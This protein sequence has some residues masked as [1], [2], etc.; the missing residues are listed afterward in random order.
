MAK[1]RLASLAFGLISL[2]GA[3]AQAAPATRLTHHHQE[4][5]CKFTGGLKGADECTA[6]VVLCDELIIGGGAPTCQN[7]LVVTCNDT[8]IYS[9]NFAQ[10]FLAPGVE[11]I[12]G[13]TSPANPTPPSIVATLPTPPTPPFDANATLNLSFESLDGSCHVVE[14]ITP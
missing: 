4:W 10:T 14:V 3:P 6:A 11:V 9:D 13:I 1:W 2:A 5:S 7:S 12:Q 8:K